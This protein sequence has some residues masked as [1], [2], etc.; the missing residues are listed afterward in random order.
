[1]AAGLGLLGLLV[2]VALVGPWLAPHQPAA[3]VG[4]P[5]AAPGAVHGA[6]LG[7]DLLGRDVLSRVLA[8]G[9]P[10]VLTGL[11][12]T[13]V[14][15][16]LG[17][18]VGLAAALAAPRR[19]W[20]DAVLM[21]PLDAVA[22]VPPLLILLLALA[23]APGRLSMTLALLVAGLPLTARVLRASAA[24]VVQRGHVEVAVARG[25]RLPWLLGREVLPLVSAPLLADAGIRFVQSVYVVVAVGFLGLGSGAADWGLLISESLPGA[26]LQ[27]WALVAPV[28]VVA[29]LAVSANTVADEFAS[30]SRWLLG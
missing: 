4:P 1:M 9:R 2:T 29:A 7:T 27:P 11:L 13:V 26:A 5:Y 22:A 14:G 19:P 24:A 30:R 15:G 25:E 17:A 18:A 10:V 8:G 28:L 6:P 21:R 12:V 20:L 3:V 16:L 23:A